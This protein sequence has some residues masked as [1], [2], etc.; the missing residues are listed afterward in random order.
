MNAFKRLLSDNGVP[1]EQQQIR[2]QFVTEVQNSGSNISNN[3][4]F[5]PLWRLLQAVAE[6]PFMALVQVLI[7]NVMPQFYL[8]TVTGEWLDRWAAN[9]RVVRR[10]GQPLQG[11]VN[12]YRQTT[13]EEQTLPAGTEIYTESIN[14]I[15]YRVRLSADVVF[16]VGQAYQTAQ[17]QAP[18]NGAAFNL[19]GGYYSKIDVPNIAVDQSADWISQAGIDDETDEQLRQRVANR[20]NSIGFYHTDGV[21]KML[22][23]EFAQVPVDHI[24]FEHGAPRGPGTANAYVLLPVNAPQ[25]SILEYTNRMIRDEGHHGHGDDLMVYAVPEKPIDLVVTVT[26]SANT[27]QFERGR[28]AWEIEQ[29]IR[30][31]FRGNVA[32]AGSVTLV[33][34]K[35]RF[36]FP[37]LSGELI[38]L[39]DGVD[40]I[41]FDQGD[42]HSDL[43]IP[44]LNSITVRDADEV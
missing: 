30:C 37:R 14:N 4:Q 31:T 44:V 21:Y 28:L 36:S 18:E 15:I 38:R 32:Y 5:S 19:E 24:W 42:I 26:Y 16:A 6:K 35:S 22:I 10:T 27:I 13:D 3:S 12:L 34:P 29:A 20:F 8:Q 2:D 9:Y 1:V 7:G 17:V 33:E 41:D 40:V 39:F 25:V 23:S 11:T 43:T